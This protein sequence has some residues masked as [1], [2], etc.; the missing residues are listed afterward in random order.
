M[1]SA[2]R[3][4]DR[5]SAY[6]Q[7]LDE[8]VEEVF[9]LMMGLHCIP[10]SECPIEERETISAVIG[11]AGAMSGT[12]VLRSGEQVALCMAENLIGIEMPGLSDTVKDAVGEICNMVTGA[13]KSKQLPL[14]SGCML[15]TPTVV[16]GTHYHLHTQKPEF[17]IERYYRFDARSFG[18][19]LVCESM[20]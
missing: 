10:V 17:R 6:S 7:S 11:L 9:S 18:V 16:T 4:I 2:S 8:A 14:A 5:V 19:A 3:D 1:A 15:S 12:C 20:Q 13:W